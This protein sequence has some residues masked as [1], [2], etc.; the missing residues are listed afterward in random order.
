LSSGE[1]DHQTFL[2]RAHG[3]SVFTIISLQIHVLGTMVCYTTANGMSQAGAQIKYQGIAQKNVPFKNDNCEEEKQCD[4]W[5]VNDEKEL[6]GSGYHHCNPCGF[7]GG[8][9]CILRHHP[10]FRPDRRV[11]RGWAA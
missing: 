6:P 9:Q 7:A 5:E 11:D 4:Y 1:R 2:K 8:S 3:H 10:R